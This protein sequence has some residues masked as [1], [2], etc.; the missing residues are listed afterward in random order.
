MGGRVHSLALCRVKSYIEVATINAF[1]RVVSA[2]SPV[3]SHGIF[4]F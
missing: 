1:T 4:V 3:L 2:K